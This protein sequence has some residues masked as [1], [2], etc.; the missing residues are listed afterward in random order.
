VLPLMAEW[1]ILGASFGT[2]F[3]VLLGRRTVALLVS[4]HPGPRLNG[5]LALGVA[6]AATI[7]GLFD[8]V[9]RVAPTVVLIALLVGV[10]LG[11]GE[12]KMGLR[13]AADTPRAN[14]SWSAA[15]GLIA[16]ASTAFLRNATQDLDALRIISSFSSTQ[17]L[18]RAVT[19]APNNV[20]ARALLSYALVSQGRCDLARPHLRRAAQM[21]PF[22]LFFPYLQARCG[23]ANDA[24]VEGGSRE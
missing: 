6:A 10:A 13:S 8:S 16:I 12:E 14:R 3:L 4:R 22:S 21:Q 23:H 9:L 5:I 20:E 15:L 18:V 1:G 2:L 7:L 24:G 11:A 17:D 19:V